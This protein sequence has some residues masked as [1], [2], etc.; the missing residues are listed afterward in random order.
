MT[1][2]TTIAEK[3]LQIQ[4][5]TEAMIEADKL[6][7][8]TEQNYEAETTIFYFEDESSV[9]FEGLSQTVSLNTK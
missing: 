8:E 1:K 2:R 5:W 6:S 7:I 9:I 3:I 4:S